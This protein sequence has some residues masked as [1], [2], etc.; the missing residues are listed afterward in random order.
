MTVRILLDGPSRPGGPRIARALAVTISLP[1]IVAGVIGWAGFAAVTYFLATSSAPASD[2][3]NSFPAA[4][5]F[6]AAALIGLPLGIRLLRGKRRVVLFLRRF[7]FAD[8]TKALSYAANAA[9]GRSARLVT[10]DDA[11]V[12]VVGGPAAPRR[13]AGLVIVTAI[14]AG[15]GFG[16]WLWTKGLVIIYSDTASTPTTTTTA[17]SDVGK[18]IASVFLSA[19]AAMFIVIVISVLAT[20]FVVSVGLFSAANY[21]F[22]RR[23]ERAKRIEINTMQDVRRRSRLIAKRGSRIFAPRL[24]VVTVAN[25]V[26][27]QAVSCFARGSAVVIIDVSIPSESVLWEIRALLPVMGQRCI[28]VGRMDLLTQQDLAGRT[29]VVSPIASDIDGHEV[30]VYRAD[31]P[32]IRRFSRALR[33]TIEVRARQ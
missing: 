18:A 3:R 30:L 26:W 7:G 11:Q 24:L 2:L 1:L 12:K 28:L 32:G 8:A 4:A 29:V 27:Q 6:P 21:G 33:A 23:A 19:I 15:C 10:F 25:E 22:A 31:G 16:W 13:L 14:A 17:T 5:V 20:S 9:I